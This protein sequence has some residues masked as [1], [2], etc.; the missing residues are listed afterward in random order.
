MAFPSL[1]ILY[2]ALTLLVVGCGL[3][4]SPLTT[5]V[6]LLYP[7]NDPRRDSA[8]TIFYMGINL[9]AFISPLLCGWLAENTRGRF[10]SGFTVAGIGMV[11]AMLT[12]LLGLSWIVQMDQGGSGPLPAESESI[13]APTD[14][15]Q[16]T[17][18]TAAPW[19]TR[20]APR[21]LMGL[22]IVLALIAPAGALA[23]RVSWD[24]VI[25]LELAAIAALMFGAI[26]AAVHPAAR[27][28]VLA[29]LMVTVF[30]TFYLVGAGQSG[31]AINLW[32]DQN[33]NRR[34]D[35]ATPPPDLFPEAAPDTAALETEPPGFWDRWTSLFERL[36]RKDGD[37]DKSWSDWWTSLW[38]PM[39]TAWFQSINPLLILLL[40]PV[41]AVLWTSLGRRG[42]NPSVPT[43]M[44][45][46]L[47]LMALAF[48][49]MWAAA[50][51]EAQ[52]TSVPFRGANLPAALVVNGHG[53][54]CLVKEGK[55][56]EPCHA[57]RLFFDAAGRRLRAVGVFPDLVRDQIVGA[58][59]PADFVHKVAELRKEAAEAAKGPAG[60][61]RHVQLAS[62]PPGFDLRYGGFGNARGNKEV[63]YDD[64]SRNL[65]TTILL[66]DKEM[67]GLKVAAG[68]PEVRAALNQ[69][70]IDS[71]SHRVGP[72]WLLGFFLL[73]TLGELCLL[74]VGMSVVS[75]LAP[76]R[77][78]TMLMGLWL[79][80][81]AF[82]NFL[83]GALGEKWGT[84]APAHY[85]VVLLVIVGGAALLLFA[86]GRKIGA[87]MDQRPQ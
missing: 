81:F 46:G 30:S 58:T 1:D 5:Q 59:A 43:K 66:D 28:R 41:F 84:W 62:T 26:A 83:A 34:L 55:E 42:L 19:L 70:M 24:T 21:F 33:T 50:R 31:N 71:S 2:A 52:E 12:Y 75:Q 67:Q 49:L 64:E 36:P 7:P 4:T 53:K 69:L 45:L 32:A 40:A 60:W 86:L 47:T 27:D 44:G 77:F 25:F 20:L 18:A 72:W 85:F 54:V 29:I 3:L 48:A 13:P 15:S 6:G 56:P 65:S 39:P 11:I 61:S 74:P 51:Y 37:E 68:D 76:A 78:A 10:H 57:G 22:G 38:N 8:Y 82:G 73:A 79:L 23:D 87:L 17:T 16:E 80:T 63:Q 14:Q 35:G 9:G